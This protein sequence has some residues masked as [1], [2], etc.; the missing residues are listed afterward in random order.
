M[1]RGKC[2]GSFDWNNDHL[3]I[4]MRP[5]LAHEER[6]K[7]RTLLI[8]RPCHSNYTWNPQFHILIPDAG[9]KVANRWDPTSLTSEI[10]KLYKNHNYILYT[11]IYIYLRDHYLYFWCETDFV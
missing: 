4:V 1:N 9:S 2:G 8:T 11:Y 5:L 6:I 7:V 10:T 3:M